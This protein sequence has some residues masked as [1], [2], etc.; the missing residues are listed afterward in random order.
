MRIDKDNS[1]FYTMISWFNQVE[2]TIKGTM[3]LLEIIQ[4]FK[5]I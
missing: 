3:A 2:I 5:N 4:T 1:K